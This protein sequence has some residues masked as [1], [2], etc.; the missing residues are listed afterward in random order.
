VIP[1]PIGS[2]II[3][4]VPEEHGDDRYSVRQRRDNAGEDV[5]SITE[6]PQRRHVT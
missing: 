4:T 6:L 1:T 3:R 5:P 2:R